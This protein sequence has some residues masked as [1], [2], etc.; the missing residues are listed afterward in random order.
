MTLTLKKA[1]VSVAVLL[2]A[3]T[4]HPTA[5]HAQAFPPSAEGQYSP[6]DDYISSSMRS[7]LPALK[8]AAIRLPIAA[9]LSAALAFRFRRRGT[10]KRQ[11][12]VIQTQII[13]AIVGAVV[14]L[15]VG[16]SL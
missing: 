11:A 4:V 10:P 7:Q 2:A 1:L 14:M 12:P 6:N 15:V 9:A 8:H 13:L 5:A 3:I 16:S